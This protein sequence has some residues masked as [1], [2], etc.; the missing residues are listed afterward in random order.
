MGKQTNLKKCQFCGENILQTA[1]VCK[2]CNREQLTNKQFTKYHEELA[3]NKIRSIWTII[4]IIFASTMQWWIGVIFL[5]ILI[6]IVEFYFKTQIKN[7]TTLE[8]LNNYNKMKK[9]KRRE[10][11]I[12]SSIIVAVI[13][14]LIFSNPSKDDFNQYLKSNI[15]NIISEKTNFS[16][17]I[18]NL[19]IDKISDYLPSELD[20]LVKEDNY[21]LFSIYTIDFSTFS[22][23]NNKIIFIGVF[24][25]FILIQ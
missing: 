5:F 17:S 10:N 11:I 8:I 12:I 25:N 18:M 14:I 22:K 1:T 24:K 13:V 9:K 19:V 6:G 23:K 21:Y 2:Y 7:L 3:W 16:N 15:S 4:A 20:Y